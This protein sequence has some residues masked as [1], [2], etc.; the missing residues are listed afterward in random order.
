MIY[1]II[2]TSINNKDINSDFEHRK[3]RYID[4]IKSVLKLIENDKTIKPIIVENN[5]KRTT[6][7][8]EFNCDIKYTDH[9]K[10][11]FKNKGVNELL[12]IKY[13][14]KLYNIDDNDMI[15]KLTGRYK[16]LDLEFFD[17][18][19][20]NCDKLEAFI[21]FFNVCTLQYLQN[22][23]VLGL[24]AIKCKYLKQ[25]FYTCI[26]SPECEFAEFVR[27]NIK[28]NVMEINNLNLE[29]C[30]ADDLRLLTV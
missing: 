28:E 8:D 13:L 3:N 21:K 27:E 7:L 24:F 16:L 11:K 17:V 19:K 10:L 18:I 25:F 6:Y 4:S 20:N 26:K 23:C 29:C 30:F 2:T 9:N 12:D 22:D 5:G 1:L 15:I 14:I